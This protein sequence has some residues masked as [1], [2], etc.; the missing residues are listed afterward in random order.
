M[1]NVLQSSSFSAHSFSS[2]NTANFCPVK[3]SKLKFGCDAS[4]KQMGYELAR[5]YFAK[6]S[7]DL[8]ANKVVVLPSPYN[9]VKNAATILSEHFVNALNSLLVEACGKHVEFSIIHR[10]VSY[11]NDYGFLSKA[12]RKGLIDNDSF[13]I[14]HDF[15]KGKLLVFIDD[16]KITGTHEDKLREILVRDGIHDNVHFL[17]Y[18]QYFGDS[19]SIEADL[20]FAA[21]KTPSDYVKLTE[22]PKHHII[23]RPIKYVLGLDASIC[24][25]IVSKMSDD[26][27]SQIYHGCLAEGYYKIP[28]YQKSF[29]IVSSEHQNRS[30]S[31]K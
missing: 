4:A 2:L 22:T 20:N 5:E 14:N 8:I 26:T 28:K 3:Y 19:P 13:Y 9:Y 7:V 23:V 15:L 27:I 11:T 17:Y 1:A 24:I 29:S 21:I 16:V 12:K 6:H 18:A 25:D 10:K 30:F 31:S